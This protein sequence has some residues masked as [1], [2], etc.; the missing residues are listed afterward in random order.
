MIK[1][2]G[3]KKHTDEFSKTEN[4]STKKER[5]LSANF[6]VVF[7]QASN[8]PSVFLAHTHTRT[9]SAENRIQNVHLLLLHI[10]YDST[11]VCLF[12]G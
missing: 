8:R 9:H 12:F 7:G 10:N 2:K 6:S 1:F 3:N 5:K 4:S 11:I